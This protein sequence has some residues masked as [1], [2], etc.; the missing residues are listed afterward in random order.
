MCYPLLFCIYDSSLTLM[1]HKYI[2]A[3]STGSIFS[4]QI[5]L[6]VDPRWDND[7][8]SMSYRIR[9]NDAN[10]RNINVH[11][12]NKH[13]YMLR[14]SYMNVY[15][16]HKKADLSMCTVYANNCF[17]LFWL[18]KLP[19]YYF[20]AQAF[21]NLHGKLGPKNNI[22]EVFLTRKAKNMNHRSPLFPTIC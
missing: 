19:E 7:V 15:G 13:K 3:I 8:P 9:F 16:L 12:V 10:Y 22:P 6:D 21:A 1:K 14:P 18:R 17:L 5:Q 2:S 4:N 11:V 20:L